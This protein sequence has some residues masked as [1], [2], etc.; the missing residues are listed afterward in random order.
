[1]NG[2]CAGKDDG[3]R[4]TWCSLLKDRI[5]SLWSSIQTQSTRQAAIRGE[6]SAD[7]VATRGRRKGEDGVSHLC[8][9]VTEIILCNQD[10]NR[11]DSQKVS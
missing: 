5:V 7:A 1:M 11:G 3:Q 4:P 8:L 10:P 2:G 6:V 9:S